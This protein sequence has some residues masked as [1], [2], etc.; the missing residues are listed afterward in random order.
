MSCLYCELLQQELISKIAS[1]CQ[2]DGLLQTEIAALSFYK[3]TQPTAFLSMIYEPSLCLA[4]RGKKAV[5]LGEALFEYDLS[6]YL[7]ASIHTPARVSVTQASLSQPYLGLKIAFSLEQIFEVLQEIKQPAVTKSTE[8]GLYFGKMERTLLEAVGR[9]V[10][11]LDKPE[12]HHVLVPLV[13][14]EILYLVMQGEGGHFLRGY[15][16]DGKAAHQVVKAMVQLKNHFRENINIRLLAHSVGMSESSLYHHFKKMTTM[17]PLQFQKNL[18]LQEA[19]QRLMQQ[20]IEV[21]KVAFDVGY[22]SPSQFSREYTRH[23]G[24]SPKTDSKKYKQTSLS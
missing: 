1:S 17:S 13:L 18:R 2:Q 12:T 7:L 14:K 22:E 19:R 8:R 24:F 20:Q 23:F 4:V 16:Q 3:E 6:S 15:L 11:L 5:G 9:L 10:R 21:A